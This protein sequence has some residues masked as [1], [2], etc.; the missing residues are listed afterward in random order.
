MAVRM[1]IHGGDL[2]ASTQLNITFGQVSL[3]T[4]LVAGTGE[5]IPLTSE[6]VEDLSVATEENVKR[7]GGTVGWGAAG[8]VLLGPVGLLAG[9][10]AGGR[11]KE[12]TF[13]LLLKDG[14][15]LLATVDNK[16][17][18]KMAGSVM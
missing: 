12:T 2:P 9:L 6:T 5:R 3:T 15:K 4:G 7:I 8:A 11:K 17:Y 18:V 10:L 1:K 16:A 13:V 14:R